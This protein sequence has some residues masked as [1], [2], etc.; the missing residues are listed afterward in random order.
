M[1]AVL[2]L[3]EQ[4]QRAQRVLLAEQVG[5]FLVYLEAVMEEEM[6]LTQIFHRVQEPLRIL[7]IVQDCGIG[8]QTAVAAAAVSTPLTLHLVVE[9]SRLDHWFA[10]IMQQYMV[11]AIT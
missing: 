9:Q 11:L 5:V 4:M 3:A 10:I 7:P 2:A 1:V 8:N 6:V